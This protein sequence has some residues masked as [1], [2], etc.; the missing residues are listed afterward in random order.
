MNSEGPNEPTTPQTPAESPSQGRAR[1]AV[2]AIGNFDG[3]HLGHR[4]VLSQARALADA[5]GLT[6]LVLTF[7]PHPSAVLGRT[8]KPIL[9][10]LPERIRLLREAGA[11]DVVVFPFSAEFSAWSPTRFAE[12]LLAHRLGARAVVVGDNFRFGQKRAGDFPMLGALGRTLGFEAVSATVAGDERGPYSSTRVRDAL[13]RGDVEE[14][15]RVLGR[16]YA[17]HGLVETGDKL[18]R[19]IGFPTANLG[20]IATMLPA[21]GVYAVRAFV[22]DSALVHPGVLN[23]GVRPTVDGTKLR[24]EAHLLDGAHDLYDKALR[25][26]FVHRLRGERKFDGLPALRAQIVKDAADAS[27]ILASTE[28]DRR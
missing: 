20:G 2:V 25:V 5:R 18:G 3:V 8:P 10:T 7:D 1:G 17:V 16:P 9:T 23:L 24:V 11:D 15:T 19:T 27:A 22:D 28:A 4:A 13:E 12:E 21:H 6:C 26:D 14:V